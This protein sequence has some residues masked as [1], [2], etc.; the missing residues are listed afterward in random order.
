MWTC[1]CKHVHSRVLTPI[2]VCLEGQNMSINQPCPLR[3]STWDQ[4]TVHRKWGDVY[5]CICVCV[6]TLPSVAQLWASSSHWTRAHTAGFCCVWDRATFQGRRSGLR[7]RKSHV[8]ALTHS[9]AQMHVMFSASK[10]LCV[11]PP[12]G[13]AV[14]LFLIWIVSAGRRREGVTC[15]YSR[16]LAIGTKT[17]K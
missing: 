9:W 10:C 7:H 4:I 17:Q 1:V 3:L 6:W 12:L 5:V 2:G 13:G 15:V 11:L 8:Y 14:L 16:I